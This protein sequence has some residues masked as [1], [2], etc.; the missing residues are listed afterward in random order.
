MSQIVVINCNVINQTL[1]EEL[2]NCLS[3]MGPKKDLPPASCVDDLITALRDDRVLEAIGAL[4]ENKLHS[5]LESVTELKRDNERLKANATKLQSQLDQA[6][7]RITALDSYSR[8]DN[9]IITGLPFSTSA[10]VASV[11]HDNSALPATTNQATEKAVLQLCASLHLE[12]PKTAAD[13]S[14]AH[15]LKKSSNSNLAPIV[16]RFTNRKARDAVYSARRSLKNRSDRIYINEDLTKPVA[17]LF[18]EARKL[19][20]I[21]KLFSSW[22][23]GGSLFVKESSA[24]EYRPRK[25]TEMNELL[26]LAA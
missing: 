16:V 12:T 11:P 13:I 9:L 15:R 6:N 4:F 7:A 18:H 23:S 22:T 8:S 3:N 2:R 20:K 21:K 26:Q 1:T 24:P 17:E 5:L 25:I 14:V 10:E 19:V